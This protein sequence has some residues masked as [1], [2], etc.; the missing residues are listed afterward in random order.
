MKIRSWASPDDLGDERMYVAVQ[1]RL[2]VLLADG[3]IARLIVW[4]FP[5]GS[6]FAQEVRHSGT[7]ANV[8][9]ASGAYLRIPTSDIV[10]VDWDFDGAE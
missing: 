10:G 1:E 3:R 5:P 2:D 7:R 8:K 6:P 4:P 9:L